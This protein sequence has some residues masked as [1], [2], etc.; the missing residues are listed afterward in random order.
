MSG[1]VSPINVTGLTNGIAYTCSVTATNV[2]GNGA[3]SAGVNVIPATVPN[4]PT[5]GAPIA[6]DGRAAV[7]FTAPASTGGSAIISFTATCGGFS[8]TGL[9]SPLTVTGLTNGAAVTCSV[10]A[11]NAVGNSA[12][13]ATASVTP[14]NAAPLTPIAV[15]TRKTHGTAGTYDLP[16]D[17]APA[18][19]TAEPRT[20]GAGHTIVFQFN[21]MITTTGTVTVTPVGSASAVVSGFDVVVTLTGV[22]DNQ[23]VSMSLGDVNGVGVN[24]TAIIGF[25]VGDVNN[26]RSVNSSDIS[27]VKARSG[28][29]TT[30]LNF[31]F[32]VN[33]SGA[34]NSS[35]ISA[36]KARSGLVLP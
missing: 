22:P 29:T 24:V 6:G 35:D 19:V 26:T 30:G 25:L 13:S 27:G 5:I 4:A 7:T 34:I 23:R 28:Q 11:T 9:A 8:T 1:A 32:D 15:V 16:V 2:V 12:A 14:S 33:A 3:A 18:A 20:I 10:I 31:R 36:V 17:T 21:Q